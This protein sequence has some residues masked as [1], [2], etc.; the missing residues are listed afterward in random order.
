MAEDNSM[1]EENL[2]EDWEDV[3]KRFKNRL[4]H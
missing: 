1:S 3:A 2:T 4:I